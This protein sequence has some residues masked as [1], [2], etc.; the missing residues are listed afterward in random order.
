[1][2]ASICIVI[3]LAK[4]HGSDIPR[5]V[6]SITWA[7]LG[8]VF[9]SYFLLYILMVTTLMAHRPRGVLTESDMYRTMF[10]LSPQDS[11]F[12]MG[13]YIFSAASSL[14]LGALGLVR[15]KRHRNGSARSL[16]P[17]QNSGGEPAS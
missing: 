16:R 8:F 17:V 11:Q 7:S 14:I 10:Y 1:M 13:I 9:V 15:M 6:R 2:L 3:A 12:F 5:P 4:Q